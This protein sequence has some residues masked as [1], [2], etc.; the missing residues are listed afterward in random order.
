MKGWSPRPI[1][2]RYQ[3]DLRQV[4]VPLPG[5]LKMTSRWSCP[6]DLQLRGY[7]QSPGSPGTV[8]ASACGEISFSVFCLENCQ[9]LQ[10]QRQLLEAINQL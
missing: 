10:P 4:A 9:S 7:L 8:N 3:T 2:D 1:P 5:Q 6:Q